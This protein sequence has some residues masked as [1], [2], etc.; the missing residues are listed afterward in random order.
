MRLVPVVLVDPPV[1]LVFRNE[2][3]LIS[4]GAG[5]V[6]LG[7][8]DVHPFPG[9]LADRRHRNE[10]RHRPEPENPTVLHPQEPHRVGGG[11]HPVHEPVDHRR[12]SRR[13]R[14]AQHFLTGTIGLKV[15]VVPP[16]EPLKTAR[17]PP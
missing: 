6:L 11:V 16:S 15:S 1:V 5:D 7:A 10:R 8:V 3:R 13:H 12:A 14:V 9:D 2:V 17:T 4:R